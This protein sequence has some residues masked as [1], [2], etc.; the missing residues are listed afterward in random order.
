MYTE[1]DRE[2][3]QYIHPFVCLMMM[4]FEFRI[5]FF[6]PSLR[7]TSFHLFNIIIHLPLTA[8]LLFKKNALQS[9]PF[10]GQNKYVC[11]LDWQQFEILSACM[12]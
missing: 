2:L 8:A 7:F 10:L 9:C 4:L 1:E 3:P 11:A 12:F 5:D 6:L